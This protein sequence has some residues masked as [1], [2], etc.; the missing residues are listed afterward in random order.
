MLYLSCIF[1]NRISLCRSPD[2][3]ATW[4]Q[5]SKMQQEIRTLTG[6]WDGEGQVLYVGTAGGV[7]HDAVLLVHQIGSA[8]LQ[9]GDMRLPG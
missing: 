1:D 5:L 2:G 4:E 6:A 3:G 9:D 8:G 7:V